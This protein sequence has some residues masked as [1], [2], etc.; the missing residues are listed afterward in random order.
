VSDE[1]RGCRVDVTV[2]T[3]ETFR[4]RADPLNDPGD[5]ILG[6]QPSGYDAIPLMTSP[7]IVYPDSVRY[8]SAAARTAS[9]KLAN[10]SA[11]R[12]FTSAA[13][14]PASSV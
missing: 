14:A 4:D 6:S 13:T 8:S 2:G 10:V 11:G 1:A 12:L 9:L 3:H 5:A 7:G